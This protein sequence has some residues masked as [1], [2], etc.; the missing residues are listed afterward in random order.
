MRQREAERFGAR[1]C[2]PGVGTSSSGVMH[3]PGKPLVVLK[4]L[5]ASFP[6]RG[7]Q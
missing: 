4:V 2:W 6:A 7:A 1:Q 3:H 5:L